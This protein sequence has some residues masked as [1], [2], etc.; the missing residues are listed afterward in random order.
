[1]RAGRL[2]LSNINIDSYIY[3]HTP[4]ELSKGVTLLYTD[5]SLKFQLR[6]DLNF[7]KPKEIGSTFI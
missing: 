6:K 2:P 5:K 4:T 1:M 3:E 7:N